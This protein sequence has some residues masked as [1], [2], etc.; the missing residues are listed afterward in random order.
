MNTDMQLK[1]NTNPN[2]Y[3]LEVRMDINT[4]GNHLFI[5]FLIPEYTVHCTYRLKIQRER[6][7]TQLIPS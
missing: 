2:I 1:K 7:D 4:I 6:I 3:E 5:Y